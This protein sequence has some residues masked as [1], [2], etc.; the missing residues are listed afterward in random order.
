MNK[1]VPCEVFSR[2]CGFYRPLSQYNPGKVSEFND[3]KYFNIDK[4]KSKLFSPELK[5]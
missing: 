4:V 5:K 1:K 2:V 3:R